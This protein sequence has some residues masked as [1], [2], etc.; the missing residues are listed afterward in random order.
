MFSHHPKKGLELY[1]AAINR[2]WKKKAELSEFSCSAAPNLLV[3]GVSRVIRLYLFLPLRPN[4]HFKEV[5]KSSNCGK[6]QGKNSSLGAHVTFLKAEQNFLETFCSGEWG[7][8]RNESLN[9]KE[10]LIKHSFSDLNLFIATFCEGTY[11]SGFAHPFNKTEL[12]RTGSWVGTPSP[13]TL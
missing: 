1:M 2:R 12:F 7:K 3:F 10:M 11:G 6:I 8:K 4:P 5:E 13:R 9:F